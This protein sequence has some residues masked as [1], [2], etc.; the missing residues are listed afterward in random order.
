M[1]HIILGRASTGKTFSV[2]HSVAQDIKNNRNPVLLVPE[3]FTFESE[4]ALLHTLGDSASLGST[5]LSFTRLYDE[6]ARKIGG[7]VADLINE[8]EQIILLGR[9]MSE[10]ADT[11]KLWKRFIHSPRFTQTMAATISELKSSAISSEDLL[12]VAE[13]LKE[14]YLKNKLIDLANIY[15]AYNALLADRFLDPNDNLTRL[16]DNL[17]KYKFFEGK[18]V[19]ID[20]FKNFTGQQYKIID[21]IMAQAE[22]VY[23]S[24]TAPDLDYN[25]IDIFSNVRETVRRVID[26]AKRYNCPVDEPVI[27]TESQFKN[28]ALKSIESL[29]SGESLEGGISADGAVTVC[30]CEKISDEAEFVARTIRKLV[31]TENYRYRDFVIIAR[32]AETYQS[33]IE[34]ACNNNG[35]FCFNDKL[36]PIIYSPLTVLVDSL[37]KLTENFTTETLLNLLRTELWSLK[38]DEISQLENYTYLWNITGK[39]WLNKW[40]MNPKGLENSE[41]DSKKTEQLEQINLLREKAVQPIIDFKNNFCGT[42]QNMTRV[43]VELFLKMDVPDK[44]REIAPENHAISDELKQCWD[45]VMSILDGIVK[46]LPDKEISTDDFI[47]LWNLAVSNARF[48]NIP[49]MV[50]EVTFGS[51]DRIKPSR[52]KI[53]FIIGAN[54]GVFPKATIKNGI[55]GNSEREILKDKGLEIFS[56]QMC[57]AIDEDYLAYTSLCCATDKV[58]VS[59][60]TTDN[61]GKQTEPSIIVNNIIEAFS[62]V[63]VINEPS[64][65]LSA[66]NLPETVNTCISKMCNTFNVDKETSLTIEAALKNKNNIST[67]LI[68]SFADKQSFKLS[69][70]NAKLLYGKNVRLSA[71]KFDTFHRCGFSF[72]CK[73]GLGIYKPE[74]AEFNVLQRGTIVHFVLEGIIRDYGKE[75]GNF[76]NEQVCEKVNEYIE[77]YFKSVPGFEEVVTERIK[78]I[79]EKI[80]LIICDVVWHIARE[81]A[82]SDFNPEFCELKIGNDGEVGGVCVPHDDGTFIIE[83]SIDRVDT[84]NGYV[85]IVDYKTGTKK[86]KLSDTLIGLNLQMLI[87]LYAIVKGDN[88]LLSQKTPAGVLY[89]PSKR[90]KDGN[91]LTMNGLVLDNE[92][93]FKAMD[94]ENSGEFI[95]KHEYTQKGDLKN[96]TYV[97]AEVFNL[98]FSHIEKLIKKMGKEVFSG[99]LSAIPKDSAGK[100]ACEYC[101]YYPICCIENREHVTVKSMKNS[102]VI[103]ILTEEE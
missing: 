27:L 84:W 38:F 35:V 39:Q 54:Q 13:N 91:S 56:T 90:E 46:C 78:F 1:L 37:L 59:F 44:L 80:R 75:L 102:E 61:S 94:R 62:D 11:L 2:L 83:G 48:A 66:E 7:R 71:T 67:E 76:T 68:R 57:E 5:V 72:F 26:S 70:E 52:P 101:D 22:D 99:Y 47:L 12:E 45:I 88:D 73:Y 77:R 29:F 64:T 8:I 50:D 42:P 6:I 65:S 23:L 81:F 79:I 51:A 86:F 98:I 82:Q 69:S 34:N 15:S 49:Q 55:F 87:Y 31:R 17:I 63:A 33:T 89:V 41:M 14:P 95:P 32:D 19:Y 18:K 4:R 28:A 96:E 20:S 21:R 103:K 16:A 10:V 85:R 40:N 30:K 53:A 58:F 9:A 36:N 100:S 3:Q 93:V 74:P 43:L 97:S 24:F 25:K 92:H 60:R